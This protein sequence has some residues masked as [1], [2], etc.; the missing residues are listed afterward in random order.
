MSDNNIK[1]YLNTLR[2]KGYLAYEY[3]AFHNYQTDVDLY[4]YDDKY[5]IPKNCALNLKN[6]EILKYYHY[7]NDGTKYWTD[8][9]GFIIKDN[10]IEAGE[11]GT[12]LYASAGSLIDLDTDKLNFDINHPVDIEV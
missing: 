7:F 10:Y 1:V 9:N 12:S 11:E 3:N 2:Q 6:G 8:K 4:I 5:I